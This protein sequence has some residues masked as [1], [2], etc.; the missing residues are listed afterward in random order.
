MSLGKMLAKYQDRIFF[1]SVAVLVG[2]TAIAQVLMVLILP[3]LTRLYTPEDFSILSV[4]LGLLSIF[5]VIATLR[6]ELA[7]PL[8]AEDEEAFNVLA[9]SLFFS[10]VTALLAGGA[11]VFGGDTLADWLGQPKLSLYFWVLPAGIFLSG[12][13]SSMQFWMGR[14]NRFSAIAKTKMT[15][16]VSAGAVQLLYGSVYTG[17]LGLIL[18][19]TINNG[20]GAVGLVLQCIRS[21][22]H[23]LSSLR[24]G[25][26]RLLFLK[27]SRFPKYST[28]EALAN[29]AAIQVPVIMIA[30]LAAGPEAGFLLLAMQIMQAPIGL[31]GSAIAQVYIAK[32][33]EELR[34]GRL[35]DFTLTTLGGIF[36]LGVI[37]LVFGG[38]LAPYLFAWVFGEGWHRTGEI[39]FY[40]I[41]WIVMQLL[42]SPISMVL[43]ITNNQPLA[44]VLQVF[45][46]VVRVGAVALAA[47]GYLGAL[48]EVYAITGF[49]F[50]FIYLLVVLRIA[51]LKA[52]TFFQRNWQGFLLVSVVYIVQLLVMVG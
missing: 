17:P 4:Y 14:R 13:Y 7:I 32:A 2:G 6:L 46:F 12:A 20:A 21:D 11:L 43:H 52:S 42:V 10:L 5:S 27:Y 44:M 1:R 41:P 28:L 36:K 37:P 45:G 38:V 3:I 48:T 15:Q 18:G 50:Y 33:P 49:I 25:N 9:L 26:L 40:M 16:A 22:R 23:L 24:P 31:V 30:G 8:P 51:G 19:Q 35:S 39:V 29:N 34:I 47:G